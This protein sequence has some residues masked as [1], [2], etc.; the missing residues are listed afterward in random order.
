MAADSGK[1]LT[2]DDREYWETL[3]QMGKTPWELNQYSPP[4]KTFLDSPYAVQPGTIAVLGCG[5]GH[6]CMLFARY[7]FTVVA[8]DFAPSA[9]KATAEK[10]QQ[11]GILGK[12]GFLLE[13]DVFSLHEYEGNFDYVLEHTCFCAIHPSRRNSYAYMVRDLLKPKGKL[14]ALW[15][16]FERNS[17]SGPPFATTKNEIFDTFSNFFNF[18]IVHIPKDS[19]AERKNAELFTLLSK[20]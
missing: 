1:V 10:F 8:I 13:Q 18:E 20:R 12:T 2:V 4:L 3:Y 15:W 17:N 9:I 11:A 19:V 14:I 5:T 16:V 6:D 7:G